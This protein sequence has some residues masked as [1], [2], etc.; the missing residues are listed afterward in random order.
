M[1]EP[2]AKN[3]LSRSPVF[4]IPQKPRFWIRSFLKKLI[5]YLR[6]NLIMV[7]KYEYEQTSTEA[8]QNQ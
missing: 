6:L 1:Y 5:E 3:K 2:Q 4:F 7:I 8:L